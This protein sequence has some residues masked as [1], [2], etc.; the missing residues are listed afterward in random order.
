MA[1]NR[2]FVEKEKELYLRV[3]KE[4]P[5][6]TQCVITLVYEATGE[7]TFLKIEPLKAGMPAHGNETPIKLNCKPEDCRECHIHYCPVYDTK[8]YGSLYTV[9]SDEK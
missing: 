9:E 4:I 6:G 2:F 5:V 8:N 7:D 1:E 3:P